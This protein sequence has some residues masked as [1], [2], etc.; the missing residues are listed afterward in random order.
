[1]TD[2][3]KLLDPARLRSIWRQ[4]ADEAV[5]D[6]A[7]VLDCEELGAPCG[8]LGGAGA[9]RDHATSGEDGGAAT[10][11]SSAAA[12]SAAAWAYLDQL[13]RAIAGRFGVDS[14]PHRVL[15]AMIAEVRAA[16]ALAPRGDGD[17]SA[18][19]LAAIAD[20]EAMLDRVEDVLLSFFYAA[21]WPAP[22]ASEAG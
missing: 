7:S 11:V 16:V 18:P 22:A 15:L 13:E 19:Q 5:V 14:K 8:G 20:F 21:G 3:D 12:T 2:L 17:E 1:M 9:E 10:D 6:Q 4:P